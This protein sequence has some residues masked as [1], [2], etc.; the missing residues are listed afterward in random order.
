MGRLLFALPIAFLIALSVGDAQ[1]K[2]K[3][4]EKTSEKPSLEDV[5]AKARPTQAA[6]AIPMEGAIDPSKYTLGPSDGIVVSLW[7][8]ISF[9]EVLSVTPEGTILIPT[10]G[11]LYVSGKKL[12]EAKELVSNLVK[13]KFPTGNVTMTL[14]TP[15]SFI[16]TLRGAVL[17]PGQYTACAVDRVE[18]IIFQ[19]TR[20]KYPATTVAVPNASA[21]SFKVPKLAHD[22]QY[23]ALA[24]TRNILLLRRNGDTL[25]V[26]IP[27]FYGTA[28]D[29][30]N[31]Y[32]LDGDIIFVPKKNRTNDFISVM[33]GV[34]YPGRYE[35]VEGDSLKDA[36]RV[37]Q[38]LS[39]LANTEKVVITRLNDQG[40]KGEELQIDL[41]SIL[42]GKRADVAL[43]RGD[44]IMVYE[45]S[46]EK[47]DYQ[48]SVIGEL[49]N[50]GDY[51]V[52]QG[53]TKL[54]RI[55][56][57]A[58]GFTEN[59]LLSGA[60]IL[61]KQ[62]VIEGLDAKGIPDQ[63]LELM[64]L[65]RTSQ[66]GLGDST[67]SNLESKVGRNPVV[68]DF[69]RL[70]L[71][72]DSTQDVV[73]RDADIIYIPSNQK[74]VLV[75]GQLA[76]PGYVP[77]VL[78]A[79]LDYYIQRAGGFSELAVSGDTRIIKKGTVDWVEPGKTTIE[80]GDKIWV[81]KKVVREFRYY[82]EI[83]RDVVGIAASVITTVFL[84]RQFSK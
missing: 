56:K 70:F 1:I 32:L 81:P 23:Y 16:V 2:E 66:Y 22:M 52:T 77:Y 40:E 64:R 59:A 46:T 41:K 37:A 8:V 53:T 78:G 36:V 73:V 3:T 43:L 54:S 48:V 20:E 68:V 30:Y 19:G 35:F 74:T 6:P 14:T 80:P 58:G 51:P 55:I 24:S 76:N 27:K 4:T 62:A 13:Q 33:G 28:D 18:K 17:E 12:S 79:N 42:G 21:E 50:P 83:F 57:D 63:Q 44:R 15:R 60:I 10:V 38:G 26:D 84:V 34:N 45:F 47:R 25:R 69:R 72:G 67:Y 11:E 49:K 61:R 39:S 9:S 65:V 71:E 82:F 7:G 75:E 5:L 31:P 29:R